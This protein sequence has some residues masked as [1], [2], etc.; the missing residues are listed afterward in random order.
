MHGS[1]K[2][3]DF[4]HQLMSQ[5]IGPAAQAMKQGADAILECKSWKAKLTSFGVSFAQD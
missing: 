1:L 3:D 2:Q 4:I 5:D